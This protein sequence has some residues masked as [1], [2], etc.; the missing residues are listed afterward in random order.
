[1]SLLIFL[2]KTSIFSRISVLF[3]F[4]SVLL[5]GPSILPSFARATVP[6]VADIVVTSPVVSAEYHAGDEVMITWSTVTSAGNIGAVNLDYSTDGGVT[7]SEIAHMVRDGGS[8]VWQAPAIT[9]QS[10]IVRVQATDL[11]SVLAEDISDAFSIGTTTVFVPGEEDVYYGVALG[12]GAYIK[13]EDDPTVYV[14]AAD[15]EGN[16]VR[17]VFAN[18]QVFSTWEEDFAGVETVSEDVLSRIPLVGLALPKAGVSLIA[19]QSIPGVYVLEGEN[20]IRLVSSEVLAQSL[21]GTSWKKQ[22]ITLPSTMYHAF[23]EGEGISRVS[24]VR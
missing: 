14:I 8:Y 4:G 10:V 9:E 3:V 22:L 12:D 16:V 15:T 5:L 7:Y 6:P 21:Y 1:M 23:V 11:I 17:R 13:V 2:M 19:F 24:D 20:T 18:E